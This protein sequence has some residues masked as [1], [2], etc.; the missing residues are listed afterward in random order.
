VIQVR[1]Q[2]LLPAAAGASILQVP[3]VTRTEL[4]RG[5]LVTVDTTR[6]RVRILPL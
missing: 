2:D 3:Q 1:G 6:H 4:E 5:A